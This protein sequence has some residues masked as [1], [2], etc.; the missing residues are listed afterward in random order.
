MRPRLWPVEQWEVIIRISCIRHSSER[1]WIT[2]PG[3]WIQDLAVRRSYSHATILLERVTMSKLVRQF[4]NYPNQKE[5]FLIQD[6]KL[7]TQRLN[8][9]SSRTEW[10]VCVEF[11]CS[12][13]V[14]PQSKT[15]SQVNCNM[16]TKPL[17]FIY[18]PAWI[19]SPEELTVFMAVFIKMYTIFR[20]KR[21]FYS[22]EECINL[23]EVKVIVFFIT[24]LSIYIVI[25]LLVVG[26]D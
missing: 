13:H 4:L 23:R 19:N 2:V 14:F 12:F 15:C 7:R 9:A 26:L 17:G 5:R 3:E 6:S 11:A 10:S 20:M 1:T 8:Q 16:V 18:K 22:W 21:K 24:I 25:F